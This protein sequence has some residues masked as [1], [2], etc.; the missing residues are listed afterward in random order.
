M[1]EAV[2]LHDSSSQLL[3]RDAIHPR[4]FPQS[5]T[6][7][8]TDLMGKG[9]AGAIAV[10][11][12][13]SA[14][15]VDPYTVLV[16][17]V[18]SR[19]FKLGPKGSLQLTKVIEKLTYK[20]SLSNVIHFGFGVDSI[21]RNLAASR[22]GGTLVG[23]CAA[24]SE[25]FHEDF[26]PM[27]MCDLVEAYKPAGS[28]DRTPSE[29]Q[30]KALIGHCRG[31][32]S[33]SKFPLLAETLMSLHPQNHL[34]IDDYLD[35]RAPIRHAASSDTIALALLAVGDL[36]TGKLVSS[37][38]HGGPVGGWIA[39]VA[40]WLFNLNVSISSSE[41]E[42]LY[43]NC[44][45]TE[46]IQLE[47]I[48]DTSSKGDGKIKLSEQTINLRDA[49]QFLH[50]K[51]GL[52]LGP[53]LICGRVPWDQALSLTFGS[54]FTTLMKMQI[55]FGSLLGYAA[56][57]LKGL[58]QGETGLLSN[59]LET[60][61]NYSHSGYGQG[62]VS[63]ATQQFPEL[64]PLQRQMEKAVVLPLP[65][66][67]RMYEISLKTL[68]ESC[69]CAI[70]EKGLRYTW[71]DTREFCL[72]ILSE[73]IIA[74]IQAV[75]RAAVDR[76]LCPVRAGVEL[77]YH[78]QKRVQELAAQ[79]AEMKKFVQEHG[80]IT[81]LAPTKTTFLDGAYNLKNPAQRCLLDLIHLFTG[82]TVTGIESHTSAVSAPG[83]A[84]FWGL[85]QDTS[86]D[87]QD[88]SKF[89][90]IP[91]QIEMQGCSYEK[92]TDLSD[93]DIFGSDYRKRKGALAAHVVIMM[94]QLT[95][96]YETISIVAQPNSRTLR[97][98]F[99]LKDESGNKTVLVGP[100][101]VATNIL[102]ATGLFSCPCLFLAVSTSVNLESQDAFKYGAAHMKPIWVFHGGVLSRM[103]SLAFG[104][105]L[106]CHIIWRQD[107]C[108]DCCKRY[109]QRS[110][111]EYNPAI[112]QRGALI[113]S[114]KMSA[115]AGFLI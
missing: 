19:A 51:S 23:L 103:A 89:V 17:Q 72:V 8:W 11:S 100:A 33:P 28:S 31:L 60:Y 6:W 41:G 47:V 37:R 68:K 71:L 55:A 80:Q 87:P 44:K 105:G 32:L 113:I 106:K 18:V 104:L 81:H 67:I 45:D 58:A 111:Q 59:L 84:V 16:G 57:F 86:V 76:E 54:A 79:D 69:Q 49:T 40:D 7:S 1:S 90:V 3:S 110:L 114:E 85:L 5:G 95:N 70:C 92:V 98:G 109:A 115:H 27:I 66:A 99:F 35:R 56:R 61:T 42:L 94:E 13:Y 25:C 30:W 21:V 22:E 14:G 4:S 97:A 34:A 36:S 88:L 107:E 73:A 74:L 26:A 38:I 29:L 20:S 62:F 48:Y 46:R 15:N 53:W 93:S 77:F 52:L 75:S 9:F 102:Q 50:H 43:F 65:D 64:T 101:Q 83:L 112:S 63:F 2:T 96:D 39:A 82:R 108:L 78:R 12:R 10:L 91:G 24:A